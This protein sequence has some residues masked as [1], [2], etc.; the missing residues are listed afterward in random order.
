MLKTLK[1]VGLEGEAEL[2]LWFESL[3]STCRHPQLQEHCGKGGG[4][5]VRAGGW[6]GG[7]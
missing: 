3:E 6:E 7:L 2:K 1:K 4:E 5:N